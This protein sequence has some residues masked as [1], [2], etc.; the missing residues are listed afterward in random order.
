MDR[1]MG[2]RKVENPAC[3]LQGMCQHG[4]KGSNPSR[5]ALEMRLQPRSE[6]VGVGRVLLLR[7]VRQ[8]WVR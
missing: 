2:G 6:R 4:W 1:K 8:C 7:G 3:E 5:A